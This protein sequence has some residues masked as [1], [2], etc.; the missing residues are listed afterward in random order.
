M[1]TTFDPKL[2]KNRSIYPVV[3]TENVRYRDTD[4]QRHVNNAVYATYFEIGRGAARR[5]ATKNH[6]V[7]PEGAG[8]VVARLLINYHLPVP[9]PAVIE[10]GAG[11]IRIGRSS[12]EYGLAVFWK[13]QCAAS[14]EVTM[15]MLDRTTGRTMPIPANYR[16][17]LE[18]ILLRKR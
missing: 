1:T 10:I 2:L 6:S 3:V 18:A 5:Q 8:S 4:G 15:V 16:A 14:G 11:L 13:D 17:Q 12:L 7:L 9:C